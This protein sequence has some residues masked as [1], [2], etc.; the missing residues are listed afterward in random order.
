[1]R[2]L[3]Q[4]PLLFAFVRL[5]DSVPSLPADVVPYIV[6]A[7][8]GRPS[9]RSRPGNRGKRDSQILA[10][11]WLNRVHFDSEMF[12]LELEMYHQVKNVIGVDPQLYEV[13]RRS[14]PPRPSPS[15]STDSLARPAVHVR[16][17]R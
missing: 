16:H 6:V 8:V 7:K 5:A 10:M 4:P 14:L 9:E 3:A 11:R 15:S 13:R 12:P 17:R 1:M 2:R